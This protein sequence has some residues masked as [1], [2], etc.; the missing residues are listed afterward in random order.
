MKAFEIV[1]APLGFNINDIDP[2]NNESPINEDI[3]T[4]PELRHVYDLMKS[5]TPSKRVYSKAEDMAKA[6]LYLSSGD[7][8]AMYGSTMVLDEGL[9]AGL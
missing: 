9:T 1:L 2:G 6:A 8:V 5:R 7:S 4:K 3:R